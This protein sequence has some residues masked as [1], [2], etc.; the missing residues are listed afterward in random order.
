VVAVWAFGALCCAAA[1][2][3]PRRLCVASDLRPGSIGIANAA[4]LSARAKYVCTSGAH[5]TKIGR[6][7]RKN[8]FCSTT[9]ALSQGAAATCTGCGL[10]ASRRTHHQRP[11]RQ[12]PPRIW[13]PVAG[14]MPGPQAQDRA[15]VWN[16][17]TRPPTR[18]SQ[19]W[20]PTGTGAM[21]AARLRIHCR[22]M[23]ASHRRLEASRRLECGIMA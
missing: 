9:Q 15:R 4:G 14:C 10:R 5:T 18:E 20:R 11:C 21:V 6:V 16:P 1:R 19:S 2:G 17:A 12:H 22:E 23:R 13:S 8:P 7:C 3:C